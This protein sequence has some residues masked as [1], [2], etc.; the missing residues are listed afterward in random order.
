M[1]GQIVDAV[2]GELLPQGS[3]VSRVP[4]SKRTIVFDYEKTMVRFKQLGYTGAT[5]AD[6]VRTPV[7]VGTEN[8]LDGCSHLSM[9]ACAK[10]GWRIYGWIEPVSISDTKILVRGHFQW[11]DRGSAAY[12]EGTP[13]EGR[14]LLVGMSAEVYLARA[15]DGAWKFSRR[16]TMYAGE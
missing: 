15:K 11:A 16:G 6:L 5:F 1:M 12:Q 3:S 2:M 14:A 7:V 9:K 10:L 4:V 8:V 13:P